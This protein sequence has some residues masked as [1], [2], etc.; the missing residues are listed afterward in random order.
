M[1]P[2]LS[3]ELRFRLLSYVADHPHASQ[4]EV[5]A[6]LEIS[7]GKV[8]YCFRAL[9]NKGWVKV[10]NFRR[11]DNK[12]A[13]AYVLTPQGVE[14]KINVTAEF[15]RRKIAE[16]DALAKEIEKLTAGLR[17]AAARD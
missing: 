12:W 11:S 2:S 6:H 16:Y 15:L 1:D 14:E 10:R 4:R 3:D 7:L 13:Y 8:N 5:A 17:E 9:M